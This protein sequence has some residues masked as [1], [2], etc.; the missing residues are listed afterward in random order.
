MPTP[1]QAYAAKLNEIAA[2]YGRIEDDVARRAVAMLADLRRQIAAELNLA[3]GWNAARLGDLQ[4]V[5]ARHIAGFEDQLAAYVRS[6][7]PEV[8]TLGGLAVVE[9]LTAAGVTANLV[10]RRRRRSTSWRISPPNL[11]AASLRTQRARLSNA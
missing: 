11:C 2:R 3:Q 1:K 5:I 6:R 10:A 7:V 4:R 8:T 9:P